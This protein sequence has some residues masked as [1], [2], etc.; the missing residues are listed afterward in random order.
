LTAIANEDMKHDD[1][2]GFYGNG[3]DFIADIIFLWE[4]KPAKCFSFRVTA[5]LLK[6]PADIDYNNE[7]KFPKI[8]IAL[9]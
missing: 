4:K 2:F 6:P 8:F 7:R 5:S 3:F 9:P 1:T